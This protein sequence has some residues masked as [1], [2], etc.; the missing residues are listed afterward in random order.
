MG[1]KKAV[2]A[3][4]TGQGRKPKLGQ[5][6][7]RDASAAQKIVAALADVADRTVIEIGPGRGVL[8]E[9]L[10]A[11]AKRLIAIELDRT[12]A[13]QLRMNFVR[14]PNVEIIE[15]DVLQVNFPNLIAR[16]PAPLL[17]ASLHAAGEQHERADVIG[18]L[19]YY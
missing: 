17:G 9:I 2:N 19:P 18:N 3:A 10:A 8:T 1:N 7:L 15:A 6:F 4:K 5:N 13:A 16:R 14:W 11:S 12:L